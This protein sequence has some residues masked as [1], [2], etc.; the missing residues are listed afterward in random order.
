MRDSTKK[1]DT[2]Q[3]LL[4]AGAEIIHRQGYS[5]TGI[6]EVLSAC[7]VP[8]GSFY[9][10]FKSKEEFALAVLDFQA[11]R[12]GASVAP[13]LADPARTPLE[14]LSAFFDFFLGLYS[15][16]ASL[17]G[18]C[19]CPIGNLVQEL[20]PSNPA[21]RVRLDA[22]MSGLER[23][24]AVQLREAQA[25]GELS[26]RLD[27]EEAARFIA[28]SWQGAILRAK[29]AGDASPLQRCRDFVLNELLR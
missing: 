14:R 24:L 23:L 9:H 17:P 19:G 2:R 22:I 4:Q 5:G 7:G 8:K 28:A 3:R 15:D 18:I 29:A 13:L 11:E 21:F 26:P 10:F 20:A 16:A 1:D 12:L 6:Q 27:P 25:Q